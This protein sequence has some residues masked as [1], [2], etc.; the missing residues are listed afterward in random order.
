MEGSFSLSSAFVTSQNY[1]DIIFMRLML[2]IL[3]F[4][5]LIRDHDDGGGGGGDGGSGGGV[6]GGGRVMA[7]V[8]TVVATAAVDAV[9]AE[10]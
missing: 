8:D 3:S 5:P 1:Y 6:G 7:A 9:E 4:L 10:V 2:R